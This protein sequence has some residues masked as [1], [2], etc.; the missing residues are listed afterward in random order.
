MSCTPPYSG[1]ASLDRAIFSKPSAMQ[2]S[3][4]RRNP[5]LLDGH[6]RKLR[7][8]CTLP[9]DRNNETHK[10]AGHRG[11]LRDRF[12][13]AGLDGFHDY[14]VIEL[15]LTLATPRKDC[16]DAAK[17]ALKRFKSLQGVLDASP[18]ELCRVPGV[19]PIN[20]FGVKLVPAVCNRYLRQHI[21]GKQ[22]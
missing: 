18:E 17:A 3:T 15:L 22:A 7:G 2:M 4:Y 19:G 6:R 5:S 8:N 11:R 20:L 13:K 14:E 16:K 1:L 10:G 12:L 9:E 21:E